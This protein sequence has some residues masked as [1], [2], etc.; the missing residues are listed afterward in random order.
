[1]DVE[2]MVVGTVNAAVSE[3][4]SL[5]QRVNVVEIETKYE[6]AFT[7]ENSPIQAEDIPIHAPRRT[8]VSIP[9]SPTEDL[10]AAITNADCGLSLQA[11]MSN[12]FVRAH[13]Y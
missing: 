6:L 7:P 13:L 10:T 11:K 8:E 12:I 9:V 1:M 4:W 2:A 3:G 5:Q